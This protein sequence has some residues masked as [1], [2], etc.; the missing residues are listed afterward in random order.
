MQ[1]DLPDF[2]TVHPLHLVIHD[3]LCNWSRYVA[4]G[5][6]TAQVAPMFRAYRSSEVW[7]QEP[8]IPIDS[9]D[10]H[11][12]EKAVGKLPEK[13]RDAIRWS[14]VFSYIPA[15]KVQR[16]LGVTRVGLVTLIHD[17]RAML[18]NRSAT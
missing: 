2:H 4:G 10:G 13:N 18:K 15:P 5:G 16:H 12:I 3:R 7:G 17:G 14:Y 8:N 11:E 1:R 9:L 6:R